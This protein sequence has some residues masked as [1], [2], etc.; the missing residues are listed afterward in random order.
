MYMEEEMLV[1]DVEGAAAKIECA[2]EGHQQFYR[3]TS[4]RHGL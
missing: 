3:P 2:D 4:K 1:I